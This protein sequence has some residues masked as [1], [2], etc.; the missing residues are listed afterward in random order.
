MPVNFQKITSN[1]QLIRVTYKQFFFFD[2]TLLITLIV[3]WVKKNNNATIPKIYF[4]TSIVLKRQVNQKGT[5]LLDSS[6]LYEY[7][8]QYLLDDPFQ[9]YSP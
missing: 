6:F 5:F 2:F 9:D 4:K 1:W 7:T 8:Y 3:N